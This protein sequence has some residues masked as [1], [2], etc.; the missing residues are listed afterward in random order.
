MNR[1]AFILLR[2]SAAVAR[3]VLLPLILLSSLGWAA[4]DPFKLARQCKAGEQKS[5][6]KLAAI[7]TT[8]KM[9]GHRAVATMQISDQAVLAQIAKNDTDGRVRTAAVRVGSSRVDLQAC[10]LEYSIVSPK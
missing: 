1:V 3:R 7:A 4:D 8:D 5:C 9:A 10:K 6:Q 2:T